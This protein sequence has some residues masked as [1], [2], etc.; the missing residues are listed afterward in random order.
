G[1][2]FKHRLGFEFFNPFFEAV[3]K[4]EGFWSETLK[5]HVRKNGTI[6]ETNLPEELKNLFKTAHEIPP[7]Y[8]V[9]MKA[10]FQKYTDNAV[11]KTINLPNEAGPEDISNAYMQA[12][13]TGCLGITVYRDG[14]KPMQVLTHGTKQTSEAV[15]PQ[16]QMEK[17][18]KGRP[19]ILL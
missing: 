10:A 17:T 3:T 18:M 12:Y 15:T 11:S 9:K 4:E 19:D 2:Y 5:D 13:R 7:E 6:G 1:L 16:Q 8:H 14:C